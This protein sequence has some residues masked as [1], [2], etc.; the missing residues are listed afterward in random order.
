MVGVDIEKIED[1]EAAFYKEAFTE[2]ENEF[3]KNDPV[4][5]T[6]VWSIKEAFLKAI[7]QGLYVA[8]KDVEILFNKERHC[9]EI[10]L[11]D[12]V[13]QQLP[14][15]C[16]DVMITSEVSGEYCVSHCEI[17]NSKNI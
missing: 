6:T 17:S 1:K 12:E 8:V 7:G 10:S 5:G 14:F 13:N 16:A 11:A 3:I 2:K 15:N 4:M 9:F